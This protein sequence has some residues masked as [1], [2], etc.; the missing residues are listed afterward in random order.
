MKSGSPF[1]GAKKRTPNGVHYL[2]VKMRAK[3]AQRKRQ[4]LLGQL[5]ALTLI[6][7]VGCGLVWFGLNKALDKFFF[8]NPAYNLCELEVELDGVMTIEDFLAETGVQKGDNI[9]RIDIAAMDNKLRGIP[10]VENVRIE[11]IMPDRVEIALTRRTPVAWVSKEPNSSAEYDPGSMTLVDDTGFLMKPRILQQEYHQL[12]IIYGVKVDK[13]EEG[14]LLEGDD[15]K[16]AL[17]LLREARIQPKSLLLIRSLNI[18]K[19][20]CIDALTDQNTR[21]KF[22]SSDFA[23]QLFKLQRLLEHCR[24][25][26]REMESVNLMVAK[27]TPV[28][29][30]MA[31][32]P[33][34]VSEKQKTIPQKSKPKRN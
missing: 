32:P 29:F 17:A 28:K 15:L 30:V 12:P 24:D 14:S 31:A 10:M 7:A 26:G 16:N 11:R 25:T 4:R 8:S 22:A 2:N 27:N 23:T 1:T 34:P 18:S 33:S 9:F 19:G 13:I 20:Y 3:T 6:V 5:C 21:V